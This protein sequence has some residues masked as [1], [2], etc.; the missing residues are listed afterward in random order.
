MVRDF[1]QFSGEKS[2]KT[3]IQGCLFALRRIGLAER[4]GEM[5]NKWIVNG[6]EKK[7][8]GQFGFFGK[9]VGGSLSFL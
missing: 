8:G 5:G 1:P 4:K 7:T 6:G 3:G 2:Q 9:T